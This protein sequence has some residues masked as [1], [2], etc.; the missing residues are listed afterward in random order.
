M[1]LNFKAI[2]KI[3]SPKSAPRINDTSAERFNIGERSSLLQSSEPVDT[4]VTFKRIILVVVSVALLGLLQEA[5]FNDLRI[6]YAK[7]NLILAVLTVFSSLSGSTFS[8]LTGLLTGLTV[9]IA[10]GRY[11]GFYALFYMLYCTLVSAVSS[12]NLRGRFLYHFLSGPLYI[13]V[14]NALFSLGARI[15]TV[16][17]T[18]SG[19]LYG[20][21]GNHLLHRILPVSLY[22]TVIF[23][24]LFIPI[25]MLWKKAGPASA[26][27]ISFRRR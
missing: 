16:Y 13:A 15:M 25:F 12:L 21:Y 22:T 7:P 4:S 19:R 27:T 20:N 11:L 26:Q 9:D 3:F 8:M 1:L 24:V 6:F 23:V 18:G 2:K 5:V 14:F 17:V 10:F